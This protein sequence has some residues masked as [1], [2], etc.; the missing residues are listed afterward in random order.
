MRTKIELKKKDERTKEEIWVGAEINR[1]NLI[2][3]H[4]EVLKGQTNGTFQQTLNY[5][6]RFKRTKAGV[7]VELMAFTKNNE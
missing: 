2:Y 1:L 4:S 6:I 7:A 3:N 5:G